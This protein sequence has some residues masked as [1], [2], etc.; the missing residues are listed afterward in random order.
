MKVRLFIGCRESNS[1]PLVGGS[2]TGLYA[3]FSPA[4]RQPSD[5]S[6]I[7]FSQVDCFLKNK[8]ALQQII[9]HERFLKMTF[10]KKLFF[11]KNTFNIIK[12]NGIKE[13]FNQKQLLKQVLKQFNCKASHFKYF[14]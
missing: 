12:D 2:K 8:F 10:L 13:Q 14:G 9:S 3:C 4:S 11:C 1:R 6:T 7:C 5:E